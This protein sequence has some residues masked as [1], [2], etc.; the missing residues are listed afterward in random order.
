M[1]LVFCTTALMTM[2]S[3]QKRHTEDQGTDLT[4][5]EVHALQMPA[6]AM[7]LGRPL[8]QE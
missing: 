4:E 6:G 3:E 2:E 7:L 8:L 5:V 1:Q